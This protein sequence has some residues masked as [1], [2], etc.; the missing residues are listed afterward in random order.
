MHILQVIKPWLV[1]LFEEEFESDV[2]ESGLKTDC[3]KKLQLAQ[4]G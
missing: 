1:L 4:L 3:A 2:I